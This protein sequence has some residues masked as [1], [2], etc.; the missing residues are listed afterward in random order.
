MRAVMRT[1]MTAA[2]RARPPASLTTS[3][4]TSLT[5]SRVAQP[6]VARM[7]AARWIAVRMRG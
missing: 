5:A 4:T 7:A 2:R 6:G 1:R 3:L